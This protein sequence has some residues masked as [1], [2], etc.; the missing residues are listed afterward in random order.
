MWQGIW[1][2]LVQ[3]IADPLSG[4]KLRRLK[5]LLLLM[6]RRRAGGVHQRNV[7]HVSYDSVTPYM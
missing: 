6:A 3:V 5:A 2:S 7:N 4:A 1:S